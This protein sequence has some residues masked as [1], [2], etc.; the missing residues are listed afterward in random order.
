[1]DFR[2]RIK[3]AAEQ[4]NAKDLKEL[5][6]FNTKKKK[7]DKPEKLVEDACLKWMRH[8]MN[9]DVGIYEAKA[10][11]NPDGTYRSSRMK[12][13]VSDCMGI[14][15]DGV[16]IY[17]EFKAKDKRA[18]FNKPGNERQREFLI[19]KINYFAF[20]VVVD[21]LD[22]LTEYWDKWSKTLNRNGKLAARDYL[23]D[24]LPKR[25]KED[26]ESPDID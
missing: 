10:V 24:A 16:P 22:K 4:A 2:T 20:A 17:I 11:Y 25:K 12:A 23:L 19:N 15:P 7:Y 5:Q 21:S 26:D 6:G 13:G 3:A 18:T 14:T 8:S 1:M 9:W